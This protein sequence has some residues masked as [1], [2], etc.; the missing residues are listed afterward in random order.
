MAVTVLSP[1]L[2]PPI[3]NNP[4]GPKNACHENQIC[5]LKSLPD[6]DQKVQIIF[7]I[8]IFLTLTLSGFEILNDA[9]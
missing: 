5:L 7:C 8:K 9:T 4:C 1:Y 3:E 2:Q 6:N